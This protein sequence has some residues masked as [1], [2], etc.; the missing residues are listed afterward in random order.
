MR[1]QWTGR[2]VFVTGATG[3]VGAWLVKELLARGASVVALVQ[4]A[5]PQSELYRSGD[6][7]RISVVNGALEEFGTLER[8]INLHEIDT[9][10]HLGAQ[11]IVGVAHRSPLPTF[12]AN[13]RG[14]YHLLEACRLHRDRVKRVVI[15][16]SDKAYGEQ[17]DLPYR[18]EMPLNG[19]HPYEVSKSCADLLAQSYHHT[20]GLPVAIARCG[21]I[22]GGGDLN[23]SR[24]VPGTIRSLLAGERPIIR[25]DG[26]FVRDYIYVKDVVRAYLRL[27]EHLTGGRNAGEGF[28]FSM[29]QPLTVL[30][31]VLRIRK[32][33]DCEHIEPD[34]QNCA[35]GEIKSQY[36]SSAKA[37]SLLQWKPE[38]DLDS[39]LRETIGWYHGFLRG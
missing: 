26:R 29:E 17:A 5:D 4:D 24:I 9:V 38:F 1:P 25:S 16:S 20:Y 32:L 22:Y 18:E 30:D 21:N 23:W 6:I 36:L 19:R 33:M 12:E 2:R 28:N 10:F 7:Q 8:A 35:Q 34:V 15:A 31:L 14:T 3:V 39:G 11:T 13:I 37:F 27:A